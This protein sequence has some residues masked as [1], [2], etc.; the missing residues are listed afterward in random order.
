M[1]TSHL[2]TDQK[3]LIDSSLGVDRLTLG[4]RTEQI[5]G[6]SGARDRCFRR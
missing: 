3:G 6:N 4:A 1:T 5:H 2:T